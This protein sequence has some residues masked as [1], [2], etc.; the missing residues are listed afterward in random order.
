[1]TPRTKKFL[2][3]AALVGL[4]FVGAYFYA[5]SFAADDRIFITDS[6]AISPSSQPLHYAIFIVV[7]LVLLAGA[8]YVGF[9]IVAFL[10]ARGILFKTGGAILL[11]AAV[12][13]GVVW[14]ALGDVGDG[15]ADI[16]FSGLIVL[17]L[18]VFGALMIFGVPGR[19][20]TRM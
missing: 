17:V 7:N 18:A 8:A 16:V 14:F 15:M 12:V 3:I 11:I 13:H 2:E 19:N 6:F 4:A 20:A 10:L 1:M 9:L 5:S